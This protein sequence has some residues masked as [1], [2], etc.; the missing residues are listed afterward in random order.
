MV[1][2]LKNSFR[3]LRTQMFGPSLDPTEQTFLIYN[4]RPG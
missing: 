2:D 4:C 1:L 3:S